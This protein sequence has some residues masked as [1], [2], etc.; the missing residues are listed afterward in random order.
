LWKTLVSIDTSLETDSN[1]TAERE[2]HR[3]KHRLQSRSTDDGIE[4]DESDEL[5]K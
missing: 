3:P 2:E 5:A 1:V 4:I